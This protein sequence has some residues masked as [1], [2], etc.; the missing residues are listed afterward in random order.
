MAA[1]AIACAACSTPVPQEFWNREEGVRCPGCGRNLRAAVF[2][3][4]SNHAL[5]ASPAALQ[6]ETEAS[7]FYHPQSR[8][9]VPCQQCGRFLCALCDLEVDG[10]HIC[11]RCF[12]SAEKVEPRRVMYDSMALALSTFPMLLFWPALVG[13]PWALFIVLRRWNAPSSI[14]PRT[15]IRFVL[16]ALFALAEIGFA[17]FVVHMITQVALKGPRR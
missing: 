6:G 12:E 2:P 14:V 3:A 4:I 10:R 16:A 1:N 13:A 11:P 15:K 9:T 7:C 17:I 5:G 8:A